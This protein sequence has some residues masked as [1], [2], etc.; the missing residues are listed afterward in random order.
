MTS[1]LKK[2]P[3]SRVTKFKT[4]YNKNSIITMNS[5]ITD[6]LFHE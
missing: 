1:F 5:R 6:K 2:R 3:Q 4:T